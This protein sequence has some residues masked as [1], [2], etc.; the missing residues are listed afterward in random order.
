MNDSTTP[1]SPHSIA[2]EEDGDHSSPDTDDLWLALVVEKVKSLHYGV[3]Q[4]VIRDSRI[5]QVESTE[6]FR[7]PPSQKR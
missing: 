6:R 5:V 1:H 7:S 3:V 4:I 2:N